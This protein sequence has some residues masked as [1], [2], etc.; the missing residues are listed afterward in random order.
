MSH[1]RPPYAWPRASPRLE[2]PE[3]THY[4]RL[5]VKPTASE[6]EIRMAFR[7]LAKKMHPDVSRD[8]DAEN[9]FILLNEAHQSLVDSSSRQAYDKTLQRVPSGSG[10]RT[11]EMRWEVVDV[12]EEEEDDEE[13]NFENWKQKGTNFK[14]SF[15]SS[16]KQNRKKSR[17]SKATRGTSI[18]GLDPI[19]LLASLPL[20]LRMT[21]QQAFGQSLESEF[22]ESI[23][24]G[25]LG[26]YP[27]LSI[28][29]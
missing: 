28:H 27:G 1:I 19:E 10:S 22:H 14:S 25:G 29:E 26:A 5:G 16:A 17:T 7:K 2:R 15:T 6:D 11:S 18:D 4:E 24:E 13:I 12:E 8:K 9:Q 20:K 3:A 21:A 23:V